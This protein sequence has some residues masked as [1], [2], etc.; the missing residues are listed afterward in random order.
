[1]HKN[2]RVG[3]V[4]YG[5]VGRGAELVLDQQPDM[6]L[7]AV[8]TRRD[9]TIIKT[10]KDTTVVI[11]YEE[12]AS[13]H[14]QIDVMLV[15]GQSKDDLPAMSPEIASMFNMID[16]YDVHAEIV[17]HVERVDEAAREGGHTAII[18]VGW[19][20]GLF[21][22]HRLLGEVVLPKGQT[23]TFWGE[24]LSQGHS[25]AI[26]GI[27]GVVDAVQYTI[28][29]KEA[30]N[31]ARSGQESHLPAADRHTRVCYVVANEKDHSRIEADIKTMPHYFADYETVV[32]FINEQE[33]KSNHHLMKHGGFVI[34]SGYTQP[35]HHHRIEFSTHLDS[36]PEFT[37]SVM[38]AYA[39]AAY[40]LNK[41][42][43]VGSK[44]VFD[45][46]LS[47]LTPRPIT[48]IIK[49]LL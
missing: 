48:D 46:P 24:G 2:I 47:Y 41:Q 19:D 44:T 20:P 16:S 13:Y 25:A 31:A 22:M 8:F 12:M 30:L 17:E 6:T 32:H 42:D 15:C 1:M 40:V 5:N 36:N 11:S 39:R 18:G 27:E 28:P 4:G 49:D 43:D 14:D 37:S 33:L 26:K 3:I 38:V 35:A 7:V 29:K 10:L 21:S 23:D 45:V 34:R 9:P